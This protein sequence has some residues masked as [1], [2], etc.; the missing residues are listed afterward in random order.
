VF[1]FRV[2]IVVADDVFDIVAWLGGGQTACCSIGCLTFGWLIGYWLV[3][4]CLDGRFSLLLLS[5]VC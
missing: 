3:G 4:C 2:V 5:C 1:V